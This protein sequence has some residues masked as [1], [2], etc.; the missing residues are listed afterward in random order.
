MTSRRTYCKTITSSLCIA[1]STALLSACA[2]QPPANG[3]TTNKL[4]DSLHDSA[5][6]NEALLQ[7]TNQQIPDT[8]SS[9]L[10]P[11]IKLHMQGQNE[12]LQRYDMVVNNAP[13]ATFF[14]SLAKDT[15]DNLIISPKVTGNISLNVHSMTLPQILHAVHQIYGY[16]FE[17]TSYGYNVYPK[18]MLTKI[19]H[20]SYLDMERSGQSE[21]NISDGSISQSNNSSTTTDGTTTTDASTTTGKASSITTRFHNQ[22]WKELKTGVAMVIG[23]DSEAQTPTTTNPAPTE[24]NPNP[25]PIITPADNKSSVLIN[26]QAGLVIVKAYPDQLDR[27]AKYLREVQNIMHREVVISAKVL[28]VQLSSNFESGIDWN[29]LGIHQTTTGGLTPAGSTTPSVPGMNSSALNFYAYSGDLNA[30]VKLL[31]TQGRVNTLSSPRITTVN[32]QKALIKVGNEN[33]YTTGIT[34]STTTSTSTTTSDNVD[35]TPFFSGIALDVTPEI[36]GNGDITLHIHPLISKVTTT[37]LSINTSSGKNTY[38]LASS[39]IR[40]SDNIVRVKNNQIILIGGMIEDSSGLT[41]GGTP[42]LS[43]LPLAGNL[44]KHQNREGGKTEIVILLQ[45][46]LMSPDT[47]NEI[48][49]DTAKRF[50]DLDEDFSFDTLIPQQLNHQDKA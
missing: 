23:E 7:N 28:E 17:K 11:Q 6:H 31:S 2:V 29:L 3:I 39:T 19:F 33:Y 43:K 44:F 20:V 42:F 1:I 27:V 38:P 45:P 22:F 41:Q 15:N 47:A 4:A 37:D 8:V 46:K 30:T 9:A 50:S 24:E 49:R 40:E 32:N 5:T 10:L 13:A 35:L 34:S 25:A 36:D 12:T 26:P 48:L 21:T 16:R 14:Q 18:E